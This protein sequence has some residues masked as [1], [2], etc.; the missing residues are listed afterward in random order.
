MPSPTTPENLEP[1]D[2]FGAQPRHDQAPAELWRAN[3]VTRIQ[4]LT[5]GYLAR[6]PKLLRVLEWLGWNNPGDSMNP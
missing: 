2:G 1:E 5:G 3:P 4:T 6:H